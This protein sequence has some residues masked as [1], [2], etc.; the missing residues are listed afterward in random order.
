MSELLTARVRGRSRSDYGEGTDM[1]PGM[2]PGGEAL[3]AFGNTPIDSADGGD[4]A[5]GSTAPGDGTL[6]GTDVDLVP[7][8]SIDPISGGITGAALA[9]TAQFDGT[10]TPLDAYLNILIDDADVADGASD[11]LQVSGVVEIHWVLLG[12]Y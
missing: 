6:T 10:T 7:S 11:V 12:D 5:I 9:A 3:C 1:P 2:L 4:V 8:T